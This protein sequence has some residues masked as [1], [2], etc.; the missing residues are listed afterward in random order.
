LARNELLR[1]ISASESNG[2][3]A[4]SISLSLSSE[5]YIDAERAIELARKLLDIGVDVNG[6]TAMGFT[7]LH[8]AIN[9]VELDSVAFLLENCADPGVPMSLGPNDEGSR[10]NALEMA[11]LMER[12]YPHMGY[13]GVIEVLQRSDL[14]SG[15]NFQ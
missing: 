11:F 6:R 7:P 1:Q 10:L 12:E 9:L 13:S 5:D 3:E 4:L 2:V 8:R 14:G 15:C